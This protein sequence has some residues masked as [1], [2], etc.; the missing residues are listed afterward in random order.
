MILQIEMPAGNVMFGASYIVYRKNVTLSDN[1]IGSVSK[2]W[3]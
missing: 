3:V 2:L 1:M